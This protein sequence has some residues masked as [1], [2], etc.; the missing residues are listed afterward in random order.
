MPEK[1]ITISIPESIGDKLDRI[2]EAK[3]GYTSRA[4]IVK[5]A[6]RDKLL[7]INERYNLKIWRIRS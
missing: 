5:E 3:L 7:V 2:I 4:E 1:Y 6:I